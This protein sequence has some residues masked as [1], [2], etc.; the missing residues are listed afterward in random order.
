MRQVYVTGDPI[1]LRLYDANTGQQINHVRAVTIW[2]GVTAASRIELVFD[3]AANELCELVAAPP[4]AKLGAA[5]VD[6]ML[7]QH[8][9]ALSANN[10]GRCLLGAQTGRTNLQFPPPATAPTAVCDE[11]H[12][13]GEYTCPVTAKRSLCSKGCTTKP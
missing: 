13:T 8:A 10:S 11:C 9:S 2:A 4:A 12:G 5:L 6:E 3:N 7:A 1:C